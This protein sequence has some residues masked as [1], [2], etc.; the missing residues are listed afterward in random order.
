MD[1]IS[2]RTDAAT[3]ARNDAALV[4]MLGIQCFALFVA[5]PVAALGY[6]VLKAIA[7]LLLF[8]FIFLVIFVAPDRATRTTAVIASIGGL[9]TAVLELLLPSTA[10]N[11]LAHAG[12]IV[13]FLVLSYAVARAVLA[14]GPITTHRVLGAIVLYLNIALFFATAYRAI[15]DIE[16]TAFNGLSDSAEGPRGFAALIYFSFVTLT[17]TGYGDLLPINPIARSLANLEAV[18]GQL[19]PATLLAWLVARHLEDKRR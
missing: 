2:H 4:A 8:G 13:G 1:V 15:S 3:A 18:I 19:Y 7:D 11:L 6:P 10:T 5:A 14:P 16:P 12:A 17:S 9:S